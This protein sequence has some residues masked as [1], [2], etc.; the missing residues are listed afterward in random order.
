MSIFAFKS[1]VRNGEVVVPENVVLPENSKVYIVI[2][3]EEELA[4][5][6]TDISEFESSESE[7]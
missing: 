6:S 5:S 4:T 3:N 2:P 1:V 7:K